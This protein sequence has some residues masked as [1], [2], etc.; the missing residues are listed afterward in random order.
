L[1]GLRGVRCLLAASAASR[2]THDVTG[3]VLVV[4]YDAINY[5]LRDPGCRV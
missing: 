5:D 2:I 3:D 4:G 1:P